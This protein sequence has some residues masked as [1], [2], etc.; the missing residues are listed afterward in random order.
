MLFL[1]IKLLYLHFH[2][3]M[4]IVQRSSTI[5]QGFPMAF[6]LRLCSDHRSHQHIAKLHFHLDLA[7]HAFP[8]VARAPSPKIRLKQE[9]F[10]LTFHRIL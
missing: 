1:D 2:S 6:L 7:E 8:E 9:K 3:H 5:P 10:P 4:R